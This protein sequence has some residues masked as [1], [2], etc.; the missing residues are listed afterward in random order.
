[1]TGKVDQFD[2]SKDR[3]FAVQHLHHLIESRESPVIS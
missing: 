1:M 2:I 3:K